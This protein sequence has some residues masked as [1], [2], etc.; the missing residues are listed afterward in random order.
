MKL[1]KVNGKW[2]MIGNGPELPLKSNIDNYEK[3]FSERIIVDIKEIIEPVT[4]DTIVETKLVTWQEQTDY[5]REQNKQYRP[6]LSLAE[7]QTYWNE[8][9]KAQAVNE[10]ADGTLYVKVKTCCEEVCNC[11]KLTT[12]ELWR[13]LQAILQERN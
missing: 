11:E 2:E 7:R 13:R 12:E 3:P 4:P 1:V 10:M 6:G 5:Y 9:Q 8:L